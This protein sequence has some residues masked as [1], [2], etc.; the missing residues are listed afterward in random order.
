MGLETA[1]YIDGLVASNPTATDP[2]AQGDDHLRLI[3][4]AILATFPSI[5]GAVT[6]THTQL[7][8]PPLAETNPVIIGSITEDVYTLSGTTPA[9][10]PDNGTIQVWALTGASTPTDAIAAGQSMTLLVDDGTGYTV[11]WPSVTWAGGV[12]PT[13]PTSGYSVIVLFKVAS[14][15]YGVHV[16]D[17]A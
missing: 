13:L 16:G 5:T 14:T 7:N 1:T 12:A 4:A 9:L 3:K 15:L 6:R 17:V 10:E 8:V 2:K 11:T